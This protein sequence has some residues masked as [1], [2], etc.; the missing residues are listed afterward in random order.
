[1]LTLEERKHINMKMATSNQRSG[2]LSEI[3]PEAI[4]SFSPLFRIVGFSLAYFAAQVLAFQFPESFGLV[5]AIWPAAGVAL[6]SLLL[7]P[8]RLWPALLGCLFLAGL[9]ANLTTPRTFIVSAGFMSANICETA[10]SAWLITQLCGDRIRF[11]RIREVAAL[12]A[13]ASIINAVTAAIGGLTACLALG[14]RFLAFYQTW[15]VADALGL[16]LV[17]PV[18]MLCADQRRT[19]KA[20][21]WGLTIETACLFGLGCTAAWFSFGH[22][23]V[24]SAIEVNPYL[25]PVF[26]IW[27]A[28]RI[29]PC[30]TSTLTATLSAIAVGCTAAEI[31]TFPLGGTNTFLHL[32]AVQLFL[33]VLGLT[34]LLL[35]AA[36]AQ[37][38]ESH[39]LLQAVVEGTLDA[40][41]VKDRQGRYLLFNSAAARFVG[42]SSEEVLGKDDTALF[43][44]GEAKTLMQCD[45]ATMAA[46]MTRSYEEFVTDKAGEPLVFLSTKGPVYNEIGDVV[47]LFGIA[48]DI[49]AY[50][51]AT[52]AVRALSSRQKAI[53]AAIPDI[54]M[55]VDFNKVYRWA[56]QAGLN[57]FGD[58]VIGKEA[59][60]YFEGEETVS[61]AIQPLFC[62]DENVV[63]VESWQRRKDGEKRLLLW[64]C[65][66]L[67]DTNGHVTGALSSAHDITELNAEEKS[68]QDMAEAKTKFTS[69]VSHELRSPL[70]MIKEATS[71]VVD[72]ALGP[73]N[74]GQ[75]EILSVAKSN[76]D[77]LGRLV[78]N[79]LAFQKMDAKK[80][81]YDFLEHDV[82]EVVKEA[83]INA[84][85]FAGERKSDV[86]MELGTDLPR[87]KFDT[88]KIMQVMINLLANAIK[89]SERGPVVIQ[90]RRED[91][92]IQISVRDS[93]QGIQPDELDSIFKPFVQAKSKKK[94]GTGL[95]L[96]ISKEI[97]LAHHG[98]IWVES[99]VG[100]GSTFHFTLPV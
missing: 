55:E 6:A 40:V 92:E 99:E 9:A 74:E 41:Y 18:I 67:K 37:Q 98:R 39:A 23:T 44:P 32:I 60:S 49:T 96:T 50:K 83:H 58:D 29:G 52:D 87:I 66:V 22:E 25:L 94:G 73:L 8:R 75:K 81:D 33:G 84:L 48:R 16:L 13:S 21:R 85:L 53:L 31:G 71:L 63:R 28:F 61:Q 20:V 78:N 64:S 17:T 62:G 97:V 59:A 19:R 2:S 76:I 47:G 90:T 45:Q 54:I 11:D 24:D 10:V 14:S 3:A 34:G 89:Y 88:D 57:F 91:S 77:R 42:K 15:W 36:V 43:S 68:L 7:T 35:A 95:G 46:A 65:R 69:M 80:M 72:E 27:A 1:L 70:A 12:A 79:V 30:G 93:G 38:R 26:V 100:K 86:M 4:H 5:A 51:Q 82:N 56:N